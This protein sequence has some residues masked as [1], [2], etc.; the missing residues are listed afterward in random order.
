MTSAISNGD[1]S[2]PSAIK[3]KIQVGDYNTNEREHLRYH[4]KLWVPGA[5]ISSDTE[6]NS[7]ISDTEP[8]DILRTKLI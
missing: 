5:P 1:H 7:M 8:L 2:L 6:F 4:G 3:A